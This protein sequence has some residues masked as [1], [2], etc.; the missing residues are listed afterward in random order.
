MKRFNLLLL[1]LILGIHVFS[2]NRALLEQE[3]L[4]IIDKIDF[5]SGILKKNVLDKENTLQYFNSL[6]LQIQNREKILTNLKTQISGL[7]NEIEEKEKLLDSLT[8]KKN[9]FKEKQ[10]KLIRSN[11]LNIIT[12]NKYL[13]LFSSRGWDDFLDRK[14]YLNQYNGYIFDKLGNLD[15]QEKKIQRVIREINLNKTV[16]ERFAVSEN[17]NLDKLNEES[18]L[19]SQFLSNLNA[20]EAKFK[21]MLNVRKTQ[22]EELNKSIENIIINRLSNNQGAP[23]DEG[24]I[25][26]SE[27][28]SNYKSKLSWPVSKGYISTGFGRHSYPGMRGVYT[29]NSGIDIITNPNETIKA[30]FE[31]D[32]V[33]LMHIDGY[34]WMVILR[35]GEYLS[36]YSKLESVNISKGD[37]ILKNQALGKIGENGEFHFEIWHL[38]TKLNPE[39]WLNKSIN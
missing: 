20:N 13:F 33:G 27:K 17:E 11:Y 7:N 10:A 12:K 24:N 15:N 6:Q 8:N 18:A 29:N 37:R 28:F 32:V 36:V 21:A 34:N 5:I 14:R 16:V 9:Q 26:G 2:Q 19:K 39:L 4:Q 1:S 25:A 38:K 22:R 30:I 31:G 3:R 23:K 35:H